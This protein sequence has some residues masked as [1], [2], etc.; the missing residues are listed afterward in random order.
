MPG[1]AGLAAL[2]G[3]ELLPLLPASWLPHQGKMLP[4]QLLPA[5]WLPH[6]GKMLPGQ[7]PG[8]LPEPL[9]V[10]P[11]LLLLPLEDNKLYLRDKRH[12]Q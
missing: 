6:Q 5:S 4:G 12:S 9:Q 7:L 8:Q 3:V 11:P 1:G 10:P 2:E